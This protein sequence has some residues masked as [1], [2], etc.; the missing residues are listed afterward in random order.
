MWSHAEIST[1]LDA[2]GNSALV[3]ICLSSTSTKRTIDFLRGTQEHIRFRLP[4]MY[5]RL[6]SLI[7]KG[8]IDALTH[9]CLEEVL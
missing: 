2:D 5:P 6:P 3:T 9:L 8:K 4:A 7:Q 1:W